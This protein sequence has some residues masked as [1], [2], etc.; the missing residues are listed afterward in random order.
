MWRRQ[1]QEKYI[2]KNYKI[3]EI[4]DEFNVISE[5]FTELNNEITNTQQNL[6]VLEDHIEK[7]RLETQTA[8]TELENANEQ[9]YNSFKYNISGSLLGMSLGSIVYLYNPYIAIGSIIS[10]G[11]TGWFVTSKVT[12]FIK[13][14][15]TKRDES[16]GLN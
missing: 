9:Q 15:N 10:G 12:D 6:N 7:V 2:L 16:S 8:V 4:E 13:E 5:L 3:K 1:Y 11:I 14:G